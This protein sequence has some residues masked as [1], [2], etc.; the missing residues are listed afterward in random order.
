MFFFHLYDDMDVSDLEGTDLPDLDT[1]MASATRHARALM[2]ET[3]TREG[4]I[5]LHHRID[6]E[7]DAGQVLAVVPFASVVKI[8][9]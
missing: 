2:C 6:I 3:L 4:R 8:E 5:S 1:A 9:N 7:S